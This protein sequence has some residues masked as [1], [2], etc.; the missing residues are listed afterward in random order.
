[1][2]Q[3][4]LVQVGLDEYSVNKRISSGSSSSSGGEPV[5][6]QKPKTGLPDNFTDPSSLDI[7][8]LIMTDEAQDEANLEGMG[9][10]LSAG[11][12]LF[13]VVLFTDACRT[14]GRPNACKLEGHCQVLFSA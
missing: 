5:S 7:S 9:I 10:I 3:P 1:M 6:T 12:A 11:T 14:N 4:D 8:T 13:S 2:E